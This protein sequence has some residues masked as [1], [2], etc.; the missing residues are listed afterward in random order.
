[1]LIFL[2]KREL[3]WKYY[4]KNLNESKLFELTYLKDTNGVGELFKNIPN[5]FKEY[6]IYSRNLK[7]EQEPDYSYLSSLFIKIITD[8][9]LDYK[10]ITFSWIDA[11]ERKR[12]LGIPRSYSKRKE[13]SHKRLYMSIKKKI[14][15][16]LIFQKI[17]I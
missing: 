3:P 8:M 5:E 4:I 17:I 9:N 16:I 10:R 15:L 13:S 2:L 7:F 6:I 11:N 14:K 12:L 1:M